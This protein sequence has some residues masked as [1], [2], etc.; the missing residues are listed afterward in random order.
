MKQTDR[1]GVNAVEGIVLR[2]L[3]WV[4]REVVPVV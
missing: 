3:K 4:F 1:E 2:E